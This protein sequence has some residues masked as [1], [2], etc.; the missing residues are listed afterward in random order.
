MGAVNAGIQ[1]RDRHAKTSGDVERCRHT[2]FRNVPFA[3]R[4]GVVRHQRGR[5]QP[6]DLGEPQVRVVGQFL[7]HAFF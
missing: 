3:S 1:D 5:Q 2:D 6:I 7:G 4:V